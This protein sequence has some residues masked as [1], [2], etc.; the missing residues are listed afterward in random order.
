MAGLSD[1]RFLRIGSALNTFRESI[2]NMPCNFCELHDVAF[3]VLPV[4]SDLSHVP[5]LTCRSYVAAAYIK[6]IE[7]AGGRAV[8]IRCDLATRVAQEHAES[9]ST[10]VSI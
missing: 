9:W 3:S 8:P 10:S 2:C 4:E 7:Q 6:W 5:P 1:T